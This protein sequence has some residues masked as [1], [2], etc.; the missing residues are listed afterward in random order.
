MR[1]SNL[2]LAPL[3]VLSF[4]YSCASFANDPDIKWATIETPHFSV[5]YDS[6]QQVLGEL[7]AKQAEQ[8]FALAAPAFGVWPDKTVIIVDDATDQSNGSATPWP[9]PT[10][11]AYPVLPLTND[12]VG[13]YGDWGLELLTHEYTHILNFTP[14]NGVFKPLRWI[15]GTII[16]PNVLVPRW[17]AEGLAVE[18]ETRFS[19]YG[20]LRSNAFLSI[21]RAMSEEGKLKSEDIARINEQIPDFPGG[22]R[23]YLMGSL[24]WDEL[25]RKAGDKII[26]DLNTAY[27][28]R[29]PFFID[30][31][32]QD[33][34]GL[35]WQD[36]L[37]DV[38]ARVE[39]RTN[40]QIALINASGKMP[41]TRV[42]RTGYYS[43]S[44]SVS[45]NGAYLAYVG[46]LINTDDLILVKTKTT[47][48]LKNWPSAPE[49]RVVE[50]TGI[51]RISWLQDSSGFI[52]D[53]VDL[54]NRYYFYSDLY[55]CDYD[56]SAKRC[57]T[58]KLTTGLRAREPVVSPSGRSIVF[59][60]STPGGTRLA[61]VAIDGSNAQVLYTPSIQVRVSH[62]TFV[63]NDELVFSERTEQGFESL[64]YL[65]V[66]D[67]QLGLLA[68]E[69]PPNEILKMFAPSRLPQMTPKGLTFLSDKTG[70][71]NLYLANSDLSSA[72]A[73]TNTTTR[74]IDAD[75]DATDDELLYSRLEASGSGL[76]SITASQSLWLKT[77]PPT[78]PALIDSSYPALTP[79]K[80]DTASFERED[81]RPSKYLLPRYWFPYGYLIPGGLYTEASTSGADP[82]GL[83]RYGLTLAFD[84]LS[85][86]PSVFGSYT[87]SQ[88]RVPIT[89]A[90]QNINEYLYSSGLIRQTTA[91]ALTGTFFLPGLG[92]SWR[93]SL[94]WQYLQ[95]D[96]LGTSTLRSGPRAG[97]RYTSIQQRGYEISP[98]SGGSISVSHAHYFESL[99]NIGYDQTDISASK[100][101]SGFILPDRHALAFFL[102][103][104][105]APS[106]TRTILGRTTV[107]GNYQNGLIQDSFV[108]RGYGGGVFIGRNMLAATAEYRFP[109]VYTYKG[110]GT[111]PFFFRR[112]HAAL[113]AD[114]I[115]LD[116]S[117]YNQS[118]NAYQQEKIGTFHMG[119]GVELKF[120]TTLFYYMPVQLIVGAYYGIDK[121]L[122]P[123]GVF[124]FFGIGI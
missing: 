78:V 106:L 3:A 105:I 8:T 39:K 18:M 2:I 54:A 96:A 114:A 19:K 101:L 115:T 51:N 118:I 65:K 108:M 97:V 22:N 62:P 83:H 42:S 67:E 17:Y 29:I 1:L 24:V 49:K 31:P 76:F 15:F 74:I 13:E 59:V 71:T 35:S 33:R 38:Y 84:T 25:T 110:L 104:S 48:R 91:A 50:K 53:G 66:R 70:V 40:E 57:T 89:L 30:G 4:T 80:I 23:A 75:I 58:K 34:L 52:F 123:G 16:A 12:V 120:D 46:K 55:R 98:E 20:R 5:I 112:L 116:G 43:R 95:T 61:T 77:P 124:P 81:Y 69:V 6:K 119:T 47:D 88:T 44:P 37:N 87:N 102:N 107:G 56:S 109:L 10:I 86:K 27:S 21:A 28:R 82:V 11:T 79:A 68:S 63:S 72:R 14:A 117:A 32:L 103:A 85:K 7:Y 94:G 9:Y 100:F 111:Y 73:L 60:Q 99:G 121:P 41:E 122:S 64:R 92:N 45:P 90:A 26:G 36:V 113:F 93:G